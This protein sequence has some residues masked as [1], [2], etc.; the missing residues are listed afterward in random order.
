MSYYFQDNHDRKASPDYKEIHIMKADIVFKEKKMKRRKIDL[1]S[2]AKTMMDEINNEIY[3]DPKIERELKD[4]EKFEET[5]D[6]D[7]DEII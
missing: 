5:K 3:I 7:Q 1:P 6:E 4:R 2:R